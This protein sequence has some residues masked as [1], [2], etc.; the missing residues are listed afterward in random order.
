MHTVRTVFYPVVLWHYAIILPILFGIRISSLQQSRDY[1]WL[2]YSEEITEALQWRY[3]GRD[4]VWNHQPH[5]C[6]L[7][8]FQAQ[9]KE[10]IKAP[11]HGPLCGEFTGHWWIPRT[12]GQ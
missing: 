1:I 2:L 11:H 12:N 8:A 9:I 5:R 7:N 3:N 4:S 10:N 6:L